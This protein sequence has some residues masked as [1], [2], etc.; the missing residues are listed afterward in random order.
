MAFE[1]LA[2]VKRSDFTHQPKHDLESLFYVLLTLCSYTTGPGRLRDHIAT[3]DEPSVCLNEWWNLAN[4]RHELAR[5][6][7]GLLS[8]IDINIT[9][10]FPPYWNDF[11]PV[12]EELRMAL[13]PEAIPVQSQANKATHEAFLKIF[14]KARDRYSQE[15][16]TSRPLEFAPMTTSTDLKFTRRRSNIGNDNIQPTV[17]TSSSQKRKDVD[18][19]ADDTGSIRGRKSARPKGKTRFDLP[20][21]NINQQPFLTYI[22]SGVPAVSM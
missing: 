1:A 19:D 12:V 9:S 15:P 21:H 13:W 8:C 20:P 10:R 6:K 2:S 14:M 11:R 17:T 18:T 3:V 7:A 4:N 22:D 5:N 16:E